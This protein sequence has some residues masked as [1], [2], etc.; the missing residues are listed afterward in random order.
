MSVQK[1]ERIGL[2][3]GNGRFPILFAESA[4]NHN[5][6]VVCIAVK[7]E[8]SPLI[9]QFVDK[10]YWL[11]VT[12]YLK[13]VDIFKLD[14]IRRVVMAGQINPL[15]LFSKKATQ[16]SQLAI[17]LASLKDKRADS[18]FG[19]IADIL[20][21]NSISLEDSRMFLDDYIPK[22]TVLTKLQP[23]Q[24]QKDDIDFGF[25]IAKT[26]GSVD[27]GQTV[28]IKNKIVVAVEAIE[29]T[30]ITIRRAGRIAGKGCV[31]VKTNKPNQDMRFD[32]P[33]I[34]LRTLKNLIRIKA[35]C[36][37]IESEKTIILDKSSCID[38]ADKHSISIIAL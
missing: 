34:G 16:N 38:L 28:V 6:D 23:T 20:Q 19:A 24:A 7:K 31:V 29:G 33:L 35:S 22:K 17:F 5:V 1:R 13:L 30:D 37:A 11:D 3:A 4:K 26:I 2:I 12:E 15:R 36:L 14:G 9:R 25:Q 18:V 8:T 21:K 27:I 32:V 10:I